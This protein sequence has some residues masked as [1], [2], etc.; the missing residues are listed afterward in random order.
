M[1]QHYFLKMKQHWI[2]KQIQSDLDVSLFNLNE[3]Y[4]CHAECYKEVIIISGDEDYVE[5][6]IE[7]LVPVDI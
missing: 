3:E 6:S 2:N 1:Q 4:S 7:R 5:I